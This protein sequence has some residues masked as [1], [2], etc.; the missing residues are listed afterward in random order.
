MS[1]FAFCEYTLTRTEHAKLFI[2]ETLSSKTFKSKSKISVE[3]VDIFVYVNSKFIY[4]ER[5]IKMQLITLYVDV[6]KQNCGLEQQVLKNALSLTFIAPRRNG[7][8][9]NEEAR[10]YG[11]FS[12]RN[13]LLS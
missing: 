5:H 9:R 10:L 4:V 12:S 3:N 8:Q 13:N 1:E 7:L 2:M 6:I 11:N